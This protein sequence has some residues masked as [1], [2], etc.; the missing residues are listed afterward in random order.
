MGRE[1]PSSTQALLDELV[2][3]SAFSSR[4]TSSADALPFDAR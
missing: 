1:L 3:A 2:H 4:K